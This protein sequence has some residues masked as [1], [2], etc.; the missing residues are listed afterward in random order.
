MSFEKAVEAIIREAQA[1]G[2]FE[3]LPGE[4]KPIDLTNYFNTP[5]DVRLAQA[6]LKNA[7]M[8]PVEIEV[9]HEITAL[10]EQLNGL[11]DAE[12]KNKHQKELREKQLQFSLMMERHIQRRKK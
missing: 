7:G 12:Q 8:I 11:A 1:R 9:L 6:M 4:G 3:N 5:E 2:D 10:K